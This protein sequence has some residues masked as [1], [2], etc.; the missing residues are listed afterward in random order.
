[1]DGWSPLHT[2]TYYDNYGVMMILL[3]GGA[4]VF[5]LDCDLNFPINHVMK[6]H[7]KIR[8]IHVSFDLE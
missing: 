1:M 2:A 6:G 3:D 5:A 7:E 4:N 8:K